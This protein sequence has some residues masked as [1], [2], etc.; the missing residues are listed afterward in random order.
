MSPEQAA[1]QWDELGPAS[2]V[3]SL[4]ATLY[5]LLAGQAPISA[6]ER[7]DMPGRVVK[8]EFPGPRTVDKDVPRALEAICLKAMGATRICCRNTPGST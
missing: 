3:Y 2:D 6:D 5:T 8:G 4:G 7:M 1:G